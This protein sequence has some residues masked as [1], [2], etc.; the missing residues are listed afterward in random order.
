[1]NES[2]L[3][4]GDKVAVWEN[5]RLGNLAYTVSAIYFDKTAEL[6]MPSGAPGGRYDIRRLLKLTP[7]EADRKDAQNREKTI[8]PPK[9]AH[10]VIGNASA[11]TPI[12]N[13]TADPKD[14]LGIKRQMQSNAGRSD[15]IGFYQLDIIEG[16]LQHD[17]GKIAQHYAPG[18]QADRIRAALRKAEK[19]LKQQI[20]EKERKFAAW[21]GRVSK[22]DE[23]L[24]AKD[25]ALQALR[26]E[27]DRLQP[28]PDPRAQKAKEDAQRRSQDKGMRDYHRTHAFT[29]D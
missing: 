1:M 22:D 28:L 2:E 27:I 4:V 24:S 15:G 19:A 25:P 14:W 12:C 18:G 8:A 9:S 11:A 17:S 5:E 29:G 23:H 10:P 6:T 3:R 13:F 16:L 20:A 26:A 7:D 21:G